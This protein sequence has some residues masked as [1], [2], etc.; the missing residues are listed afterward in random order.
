[1][2]D[3]AQFNLGE[4]QKFIT[5]TGGWCWLEVP[6]CQG[7]VVTYCTKYVLKDGDLT[8]SDNLNPY[9]HDQQMALFK[10]QRDRAGAQR[11]RPPKANT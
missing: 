1:M 4:W 10:P 11:L 3:P 2:A 5:E 6:K 7:D 8:L 9:E